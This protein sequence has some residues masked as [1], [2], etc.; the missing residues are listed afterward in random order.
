MG[1]SGGV[2]TR[3]RLARAADRHC[4]TSL[5]IT[6]DVSIV[7][8]SL[9]TYDLIHDRQYPAVRRG[10]QGVPGDVLDALLRP[11]DTDVLTAF[12]SR[13]R[14][15]CREEAAA[16]VAAESSTGTWTAVWT[17]HLMTSCA[18]RPG[19]PDRSGCRRRN[20]AL[21]YIA[22]PIDLFEEG[23]ISNMMRLD[24][25]QR[26]RVQGPARAAT[27]GSAH[28]GRLHED[29]PGA[30]ERDPGRAR[31]AEQVRPAAARRTLKPK[32][33]FSAKQLRPRR[34]RG[35]VRRARLHQGRREH[36][37]QPFMRWRDRYSS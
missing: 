9:S 19:V 33:G 36:H 27:R 18:T 12:R 29:L 34:S 37:S 21:A 28:S 13:R 8:A 24:H 30:A 23:S 22:Y 10:R 31:H 6:T 3:P 14:R 25:R 5:S 11:L 16:A 4:T 20:Q 15:A 26:V 7:H 32:L 17:D 2:S 1:H 35:A